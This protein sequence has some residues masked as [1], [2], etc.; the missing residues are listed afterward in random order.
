MI[1]VSAVCLRITAKFP[2]F[3]T[4]HI[5]AYVKVPA[6]GFSLGRCKRS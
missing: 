2:D 1:C 6:E 5:E 4:E 3:D